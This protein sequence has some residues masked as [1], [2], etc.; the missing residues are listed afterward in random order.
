MYDIDKHLDPTTTR[1]TFDGPGPKGHFETALGRHATGNVIPLV[2]GSFGETSK[3]VEKLVSQLGILAA[4]TPY[5]QHLSPHPD[6]SGQGADTILKEQ[7]RRR[8]GV[9]IVCAY[10]H[11]KLERARLIGKTPEEAKS[12]ALGQT[13]PR[14]WNHN[15]SYPSYFR[16][17]YAQNAFQ[18]FHELRQS[19][20]STQ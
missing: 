18:A 1:A 13:N 19:F 10:A 20:R 16:A 17:S 3:T 12:I 15:A 14:W 9:Q 11:V 4:K 7:F 5:G 8:L 2:F 6:G